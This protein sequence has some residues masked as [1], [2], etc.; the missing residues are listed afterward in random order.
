MEALQKPQQQHNQFTQETEQKYTLITRDLQEVLESNELKQ[1]L[2]VRE[3]VM[4]WDQ[5]QNKFSTFGL[6]DSNVKS[7]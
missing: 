1:T 3:P 2:E 7:V 4:Y 6:Y 5:L